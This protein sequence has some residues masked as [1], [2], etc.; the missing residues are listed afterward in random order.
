M[1]GTPLSATAAAALG[2]VLALAACGGGGSSGPATV[3]VTGT[4]I[5]EAGAPVSG[6]SLLLNGE[7]ASLATTGADGKFAFPKVKTPY[8]LTVKQGTTI[9]EFRGLTRAALAV[10]AAIGGFGGGSVRT[11]KLSGTLTG[12]AFPMPSSE[13]IVLG[14]TNGVLTG[15]HTTS[16]GVF[17]DAGF[18]WVGPAS[19]ATDVTA[20]HVTHSSGLITGYGPLGKKAV[21]LQDGLG[22][23]GVDFALATAVPTKSTVLEYSP[24]AY[25]SSGHVGYMTLR[26]GGALFAIPSG[27]LAAPSGTS[28]L[29][30]DGGGTLMIQG[31][32]AAGNGA[33]LVHRAV[34]DGTTTLSLP[35][36]TALA[37]ASPAASATGLSKTPTLSWTAV[38]DATL[39]LVHLSDSGL[40]Y[41]FVLPGGLSSVDVPDYSS[42]GL[43]LAAG[44]TYDW[45]VT[46][47][48]ASTFSPDGVTDPAGSGGF[49]ELTLFQLDEL[50]FYQSSK[51]SF[52]TAP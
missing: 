20:L 1:K 8:T 35:A 33:V 12:P 45:E 28:L 38:S 3:D 30:P 29:M 40:D 48:Q 9:T 19:I 42:L 13:A 31:E 15:S 25:S 22:L 36:A 26:A 18:I 51:T 5:D 27:S 50:A 43:P 32:D 16:A 37:N 17:T 21:T 14:A 10:G 7:A 23:S 4:V 6:A 41:Y 24:G 49:S 39:N 52:T 44:A 2:A 47:L 11:T 34:L 46:A